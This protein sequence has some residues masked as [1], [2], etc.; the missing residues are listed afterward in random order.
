[1]N[2]KAGTMTTEDFQAL[3]VL[4]ATYSPALLALKVS[5]ASRNI[6][7]KYQHE[8]AESAVGAAWE[9]VSGSIKQGLPTVRN[10]IVSNEAFS[11]LSNMVLRYGAELVVT[12]LGKI[13]SKSGGDT[14]KLKEMFAA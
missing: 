3:S 6:A 9:S 13:A 11:S 5:K 12:K 10:S 14:F 4:A 8:H 1:M 2:G 7:S